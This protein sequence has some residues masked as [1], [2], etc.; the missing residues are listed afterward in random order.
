MSEGGKLTLIATVGGQTDPVR[1]AIVEHQPDV[2]VLLCSHNSQEAAEQLKE[3]L[4]SHDV[5]HTEFVIEVLHDPDE[6]WTIHQRSFD[7]IASAQARGHRVVVDYTG[8][9]KSMS[10]ALL[11]AA[12]ARDVEATVTI[13]P[14]TDTD[15]IRQGQRTRQVT[16]PDIRQHVHFHTV[17]SHQLQRYDYAAAGEDLRT[18]SRRV[19]QGQN[20]EIDH[21]ERLFE[22][23]AFWD[24]FQ[25]AEAKSILEGYGRHDRVKPFFELLGQSIAASTWLAGDGQAPGAICRAALIADMLRNAERR[26]AAHRYDDAMAR[27]YRAF[28]LAA[29]VRLRGE[30]DLRTGDFDFERIRPQIDP[31]HSAQAAQELAHK[32]QLGAMDSWRLL[33]YLGDCWGIAMAGDLDD[34]NRK[35][36]MIRNSSILAH[37]ITPISPDEWRTAWSQAGEKLWDL[38]KAD[39]HGP[40]RFPQFPNEIEFFLQ[41]GQAAAGANATTEEG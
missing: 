18:A 19:R 6:P 11:T 9:T 14:R 36:L 28:E 2:C 10:A 35:A 13:A 4:R 22:S 27:L 25:L 21:A 16:L 26:A 31:A 37:G 33:N 38:L 32:A 5:R 7:A 20:P 24:R 41:V 30:F 12:L 15:P 17:T 8:G 40:E 1:T 3:E 29:Q 34:I 23:F 39:R